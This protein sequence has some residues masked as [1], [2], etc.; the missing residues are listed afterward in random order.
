MMRIALIVV[1][2]LACIPVGGYLYFQ[3]WSNPRVV[4]EL[5]ENPDGERAKKVMVLTL[6]S[7]REVPV[8]YL[9][10]EGMVFA[11]A[12]G[13]W[14]RELEGDGVAVRV[15]IRGEELSGQARAVLDDP[16]YTKDVFSRLRPNAL[17]GFGTLVEI[18]LD[19]PPGGEGA[20]G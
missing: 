9:R 2:V 3:L 10:E 7:G 17:E 18:R 1:V 6:P 15:F 16:D 5:V 12:D 8:N 19:P 13:R 11:G 20:D 14:W 4:R